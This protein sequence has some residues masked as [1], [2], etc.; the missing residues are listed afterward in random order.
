MRLPSATHD[1]LLLFAGPIVWA[2]HFIAIYGLN[3]VVCARPGRAGQWAG[4]AWEAWAISATGVLAVALLAAWVAS[5][6]RSEG[7]HSRRFVRWTSLALAALAAL[8]IAWETLAVFMVPAC[9]P[10]R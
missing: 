3:G 2:V 9:S 8:A 4:L 7:E 5:R 1:L 10:L 6:P